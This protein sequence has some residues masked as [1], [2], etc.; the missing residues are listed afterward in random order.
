MFN[1]SNATK[2][3]T[4]SLR[5][6]YYRNLCDF[7]QAYDRTIDWI[8][9]NNPFASLDG[10]GSAESFAV[11]VVHSCINGVLFGDS[12]YCASG[13]CLAVRISSNP[14]LSGHNEVHNEVMLAIT[15]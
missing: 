14:T 9:A 8:A 6:S 4:V 12:T 10:H 5:D 1:M 13:M 3:S 7:P 15:L 2:P 11:A